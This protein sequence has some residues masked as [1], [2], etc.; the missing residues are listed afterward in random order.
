MRSRPGYALLAIVFAVSLLPASAQAI[1]KAGVMGGR[2]ASEDYGFMVSLQS[3]SGDH[4]CGGSLVAKRWV[5]TAAHC[6]VDEE[7]TTLQ[8]MLGSAQL[9]QPKEVIGVSK[10]VIHDSYE[11]STSRFDVALLKLTKSS[12][13]T[14][15]KVAKLDQKDLWAP[16]T[17]ARVIG[18]GTSFFLVGPAP[19]T[20]QEV[21]VPVV[22]DAD[23]DRSYGMTMG[24]DPATMVCAGE[25]TGLKDSCQGDSGGPL[26]VRDAQDRLVQMG[27][28]SWGLGCGFPLQY[29]V[30][31][32]IGD[33][34]LRPWLQHE[35]RV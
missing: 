24:F 26:M 13:A 21:D 7:P 1:T 11:S 20:L 15:I 31:S 35:V 8:V 27:V 25:D 33:D 19:D 16:G 3:K 34:A 28:V 5:L 22:S 12:Q 17:I 23:C 9:S 18:W 32:R 29:G 30:Y 14:P 2:D 10:I 6:A 4:F